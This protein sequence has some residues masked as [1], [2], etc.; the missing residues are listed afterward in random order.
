MN[1]GFSRPAYDE[2][3]LQTLTEGSGE[4]AD[5][6]GLVAV[7]RTTKKVGNRVTRRTRVQSLRA[8][9]SPGLDESCACYRT[10]GIRQSRL[11]P[12]CGF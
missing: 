6:L 12:L 2:N 1:G 10:A 11:P 8:T 7:L 4:F 9:G 3:G 5:A